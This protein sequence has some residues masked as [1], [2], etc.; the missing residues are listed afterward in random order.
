[1]QANC[2]Y[3][4]F[5]PTSLSLHFLFNLKMMWIDK[6]ISPLNFVSTLKIKKNPEL[7]KPK[8]PLVVW[9]R[10]KLIYQLIN[11]NGVFS[12]LKRWNNSFIST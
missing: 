8:K 6:L 2:K 9:I 11:Y 3:D 4:L 12:K 5:H 10:D 1:M 7:G